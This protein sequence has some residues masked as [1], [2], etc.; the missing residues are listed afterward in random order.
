MLVS[1]SSRPRTKER[2]QWQRWQREEDRAYINKDQ[3][4]TTTKP[5]IPPVPKTK[6]DDDLDPHHRLLIMMI[7][8]TMKKILL[9]FADHQQ[10]STNNEDN[11]DNNF[12]PS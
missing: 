3:L 6:D 5:N 4:M 8:T 1:K 10:R 2:W 12:D 7:L 9:L 11:K